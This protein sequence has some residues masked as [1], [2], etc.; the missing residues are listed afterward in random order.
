MPCP[1][2]VHFVGVDAAPVATMAVLDRFQDP[3]YVNWLKAGQA[4]LCTAEGIYD[5]CE[6]PIKQYHRKLHEKFPWK[7]C[8]D[9]CGYV[10]GNCL[11]TT[12]CLCVCVCVCVR[13]CM[14]ACV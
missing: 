3:G 12:H 5:F 7:R 4:L 6:G 2:W 10:E 8:R 11:M 1:K 9:N 13:A 14:R